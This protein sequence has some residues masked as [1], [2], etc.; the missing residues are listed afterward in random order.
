MVRVRCGYVDDVDIRV[1]DQLVVGAVGFCG[2]R[3]I[4]IFDEGFGAGFRGGRCGC[5]ED[6]LD[7][8][9]IASCR[10]GK[11]IFGESLDTLEK[12]LERL[13]G[14]GF[15]GCNS[16]CCEDTPPYSVF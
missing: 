3:S 11:K 12:V 2:A 13:E 15:T 16:S 10:V 14:W 9:D 7:I 1:F 4:D 5:C 6:V 8:V